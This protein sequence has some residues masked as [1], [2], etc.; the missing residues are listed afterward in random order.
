ML[1]KLTSSEVNSA[2][3]LMTFNWGRKSLTYP[4]WV[5]LHESNKW[6]PLFESCESYYSQ[7]RAFVKLVKER[8]E[9]RS[10]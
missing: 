7:L 6:L 4:Y 3:E 5:I 1:T 2:E 8:M 9:G 10:H